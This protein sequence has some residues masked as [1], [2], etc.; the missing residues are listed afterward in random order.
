MELA[1]VSVVEAPVLGGGA[2]VGKCVGW[3]TQFSCVMDGLI[4]AWVRFQI[5]SCWPEL[6]RIELARAMRSKGRA[7]WLSNVGGCG[8]FSLAAGMW[9]VGMISSS[10]WAMRRMVCVSSAS[11]AGSNRL[12]AGC[13]TQ[14]VK[15]C[16]RLWHCF[17]MCC[18]MASL[19]SVE[20]VPVVAPVS[21]SV[22]S[23][24]SE[25][26]GAQHRP[27]GSMKC[28]SP[29]MVCASVCYWC[30]GRTPECR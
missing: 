11:G 22:S 6:N 19:S 13:T 7:V 9:V 23:V 8:L 27:P 26:S 18:A 29:V 15:P 2:S 28:S 14:V 24:T 4:K 21:T 12:V 10:D 16:C 5:W 17:K 1:S 20:M 3:R 25:T 30:F